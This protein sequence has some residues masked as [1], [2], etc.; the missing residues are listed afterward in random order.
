MSGAAM[1]TLDPEDLQIAQRYRLL[2]SSVTPRPIALVSTVDPAGGPNLAPFSFFN[3]IGSNPMLVQFCPANTPE[4]REKDS[5]RNAAPP[6]EGGTGE[7]VVNVVSEAVAVDAAVA[8][9]PL[10]P[11]ESEWPASGLTPVP[12]LRVGPPRAAECPVALECRTERVLRFNPGVPA[13]TCMV[14][15]RVVLVHAREDLLDERLHVDQ[16]RLEA[17][18]RMGGLRWCRT[19]EQFDLPPG[20]AARDATRP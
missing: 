2:I 20:V 9:E 16:D 8:A 13:G 19:R 1:R 3:A 10:P 15:G 14:I 17:V 6:E 11:G 4:G 18:G 12:S 5:L 7:F